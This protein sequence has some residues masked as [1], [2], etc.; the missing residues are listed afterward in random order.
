METHRGKEQQ[1]EKRRFRHAE[2]EGRNPLAATIEYFERRD[3]TH[4][5]IVAADG[6]DGARE[7]VAEFGKTNPAVKVIG[8]SERLGKGRAV[9]EATSARLRFDL[10]SLRNTPTQTAETNVGAG[11][12]FRPHRGKPG[13]SSP[14]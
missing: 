1:V 12:H 8:H 14:N 4:E 5:I 2:P 11:S 6:T 7:P 3:L 13:D 10:A 9:R